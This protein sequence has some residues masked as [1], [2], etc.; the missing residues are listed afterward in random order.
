MREAGAYR[1]SV[2]ACGRQGRTRSLSPV[3]ALCGLTSHIYITAIATIA[4]T[5]AMY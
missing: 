4:N 2:R 3:Q 5:S 1:G